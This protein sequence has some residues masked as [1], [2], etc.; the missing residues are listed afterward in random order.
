MIMSYSICLNLIDTDREKEINVGRSYP[1]EPLDMGECLLD[2]K[3]Q[4]TLR[5][6]EGDMVYFGMY[7]PILFKS[8]ITR[9]NF[10]YNDTMP[11]SFSEYSY[12]I[13]CRVKSLLTDG[14]YG[15]YP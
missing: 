2:Q 5:V 1:F 3:W 4:Q 10:L 8:L 14:I 7:N 11:N 6:E 13:P 9:Y 12:I 15:K